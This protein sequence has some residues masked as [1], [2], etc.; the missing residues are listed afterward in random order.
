MTRIDDLIDIE[1][2]EALDEYL[3]HRENEVSESTLDAHRYRLQH[4]V[5]WCN[6]EDI[7]NLNDLTGRSLHKYRTWRRKDGDLSNVSLTTQLSTLRVFVK[8]C[9]R[10]EAVEQGLHD[11]ILLPDLSKHEDQRDVMLG[12]EEAEQLIEYLRQFEFGTRTHALVEVL[13]HSGM[14]IGAAQS[15]DLEDYDADEQYL[16]LR[17]RPDT[18]TRLKN[19][20]DGERFVALSEDVCSVLDG[21]IRFNRIEGEDEHRR[22]PLF[23]SKFGRPSKSTLRDGIY[24]ITRPCEYTGECPHDREIES[25]E[26]LEHNKASKC[27]SSVSP[28]AIRR[29]SITHHLSEEVPETV[30]S[31]R[32]NVS[33]DVLEKHYDRREERDKAEQRRDY[34]DNI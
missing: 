34:L 30:V 32:M 16:R 13:W 29:G 27:P 17:H 14:R 15:L 19:K 20:D 1:P 2:G 26:A 3:A 8:W 4:F 21:Y 22:Q 24:Q 28:H 33:P 23:A 10:I 25:C 18:G 31:D 7:E 5:R 9:E 11:K 6:E 12:S